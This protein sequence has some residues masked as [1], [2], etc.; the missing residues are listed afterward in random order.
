M[1]RATVELCS[2]WVTNDKTAASWSV[3]LR[4]SGDRL[5]LNRR[6]ALFILRQAV[7][8]PDPVHLFADPDV[9][10]RREGVAIVEHGERVAGRG[11][12]GA[13][14]KQPCAAGLAE[15]TA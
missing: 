13:P 1:L 2:Q 14:G 4:A 5:A 6:R 15:D 3:R 10:G 8:D 7:V 12:V 11:A 9:L